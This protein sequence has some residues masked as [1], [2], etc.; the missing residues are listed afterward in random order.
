MWKNLQTDPPPQLQTKFWSMDGHA[1]KK[2]QQLRGIFFLLVLKCSTGLKMTSHL[3][4]HCFLF[5]FSRTKSLLLGSV[6][7]QPDGKRKLSEVSLWGRQTVLRSNNSLKPFNLI[8]AT[9]ELWVQS[10]ISTWASTTDPGFWSR[11]LTGGGGTPTTEF[12]R[13]EII[14]WGDPRTDPNK[15]CAFLAE[16]WINIENWM[17][18]QWFMPW[19]CWCYKA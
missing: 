15:K 5:L 2:A 4:G 12:V 18:N 6:I 17:S 13:I 1:A 3:S 14:P 9:V 11:T 16:M 7:K 8:T 10:F 19:A